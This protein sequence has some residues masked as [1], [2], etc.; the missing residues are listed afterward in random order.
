MDSPK[1]LVWIDGESVVTR[2]TDELPSELGAK[3]AG[4]LDVPS[5]WVPPFVAVSPKLTADY[6][7]ASRTLRRTL[8]ARWC[9]L[10][11][12]GL[13][14]RGIESQN[15]LI[16]RSNAVVERLR[17]RG[18]YSSR[19]TTVGELPRDL[20]ALLSALGPKPPS[21]Q[22]GLIIQ[23]YIDPVRIGH[24]SNERRVAKEARDAAI[25]S[26]VMKTGEVTEQKIAH[27]NWRRS[28][29]V[30]GKPLQ[31]T[32]AE[33]IKS[34]LR[35]PLALAAQRGNRMHY[36]RVWDGSVV[37]IA[38]ADQAPDE[39][40]GV[41]PSAC[42]TTTSVPSALPRLQRFSVATAVTANDTE[43]LRSHITY[44]TAGFWQP[45]FYVLDDARTMRSIAK[46]I[47]PPDVE[48]DLERLVS[49]PLIIRT[50]CRG[51]ALALLPRS[52]L[53]TDP[54]TVR[55]WLLGD[56]ADGIAAKGL[57]PEAVTILAHHYIPARAAAFSHC[58]PGKSDVFVEAL[59]G[60]PEGL[61]YFPCDDFM[62]TM[63]VPLP[64]H[65][66]DF[67]GFARRER[68]RF[69]SHFVAPDDGGR[70]Q[71]HQLAEPWDWKPTIGSD[72]VLFRMARFTR[73][74]ADREGHGINIM[75]FLDCETPSG[76]QDLI[77]CYQERRD[78][79]DYG[80]DVP[81][82]TRDEVL[83]I[84]TREDLDEL[85]AKADSPDSGNLVL[86][87]SP[88]EHIALR[89]DAFA[90]S[91]G[92]EAKRLNAIVRLTGARLSHIYYVLT[93]AGADVVVTPIPGET[94]V[95]S[96]HRKLV[97]DRIPEKVSEGGEAVK[98]ARLSPQEH[99]V[100]LK[101]KLI[102][103]AYEVRDARSDELVEE[104]ADVYEVLLALLRETGVAF[105]DLEA[106]RSKKAE[107][108]GA[109]TEGIQL[110][111]TEFPADE[112]LASPLWDDGSRSGQA[113]LHSRRAQPF[114][115][116]KVG[117]SDL[118]RT[119]VF[120]EF[121]KDLSVSLSQSSWNRAF[122]A[123]GLHGASVDVATCV[124]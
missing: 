9:T 69:K 1:A 55:A 57:S 110:L 61:Y 109:F 20:E 30:R 34:A 81:R 44:S 120:R 60:V 18:S 16:L 6:E 45:T 98:I 105:S 11:S 41:A 5:A 78:D 116:V 54:D 94:R 114:E 47:L 100:A 63:P 38:Q 92:E 23:Q 90:R 115:R 101:I 37:H 52:H 26:T 46:G 59:W 119:G 106:V 104:L 68:V 32:S 24:L 76:T 15:T 83:T 124:D 118:R 88:G 86:T 31:C 4:L 82:S 99:V 29:S 122:E 75:W 64:L 108:R 14:V 93:K 107:K 103:E 65:N 8:V 3:A 58:I 85:R 67:D 21:A 96:K 102:E 53:L 62:V 17:D 7:V 56:L 28:D 74:V 72:D 33:A 80:K 25:Q 112:A 84:S 113:I 12:E 42:L 50:A 49:A 89:D 19:P 71:R 35:D 111:E 27:R 117:G 87:L 77:P 48:D 79:L 40:G 121:V 97:R 39:C 95:K 10:I 123:V 70:F 43:K 66:D 51:N 2:S 73:D 22:L 13:E 91:V 36:E